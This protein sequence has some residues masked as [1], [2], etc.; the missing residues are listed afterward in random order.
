[1]K[2]DYH[3]ATVADLNRAVGFYEQLRP[4]LGGE[5]R[6]AIYAAVERVRLDPLR[7]RIVGGDVRRC[8]VGR[9]PFSILYRVIEDEAIRILV[10]RHHRQR[11]DFGRSRK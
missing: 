5:C 6:E 1:M 2:L 4:G 8:L 11:D 3:P 9:F 7:H 10:I